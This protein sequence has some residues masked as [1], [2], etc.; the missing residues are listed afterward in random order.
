MS[1]SF[2]ASRNTV[3][4]TTVTETELDRM[5]FKLYSPRGKSMDEQ[6]K[7]SIIKTA[8]KILDEKQL[9]PRGKQSAV[10]ALSEAVM[11]LTP[12]RGLAFT[13]KIIKEW[14]ATKVCP[15]DF[16]LSTEEDEEEGSEAEE[17]I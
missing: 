8:K 1:A 16:D 3:A 9:Q 7:D 4:N 11:E 6:D 17:D 13:K 5:G 14:I 12:V 2:E 10:Q 15:D